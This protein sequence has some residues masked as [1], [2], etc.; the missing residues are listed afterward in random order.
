MKMKYWNME[1]GKPCAGGASVGGRAQAPRRFRALR[2]HRAAE[3]SLQAPETP[4]LIMASLCQSAIHNRMKGKT[5]DR[6]G[7]SGFPPKTENL[8][9]KLQNWAKLFG[10]VF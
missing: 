5:M 8:K 9:L 1:H 10:I 6:S 7:N 3:R 4:I 2:K